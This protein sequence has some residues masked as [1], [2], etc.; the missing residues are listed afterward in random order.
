M[1]RIRRQ[2][3]GRLRLVIGLVVSLAATFTAT[4]AGAA[5]A[6]VALGAASSFAVLAGGGV[7]STAAIP[8]TELN[9]D[10][11][12]CP[13]ATI[14]GFPPGVVNGTIA[15]G[16]DCAAA[17]ADLATAYSTAAGRTPTTLWP[18]ITDLG[19]R[20][21]TTG[22]HNS[23]SSFGIA[24]TLTLDGEG[25]PDAVFVFQAA[26]TLITAVNS[27]V[28]L[29]NGTQACN[30]F[31]QVGSSATLGVG[32]TFAGS[33]LAASAITAN[34]G[35]VVDGRLLAIGAAITLD[36][37]TVTSPVCPTPPS[38]SLS[39]AQTPTEGTVLVEG[40][41][42]EMPVTTVTDTRTDASSWTV[43]AT[44]SDL[45]SAEGAVIPGA[46]ITLAQSGSFTS[47]TGTAGTDGLVS[48]AAV[49]L[50]SVYTYTPTAELAPQGSI[51]AGSYTGSVTQTVV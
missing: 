16:P 35:V 50:G 20:T 30:V 18:P 4:V 27:H 17:Q 25:D 51:P 26:S 5:T 19:G 42:V 3:P 44:V 21:L 37:N 7:T 2:A 36:S 13:T 38:G 12:A 48:A 8:F 14:T 45:V 29:V 49:S 15:D 41:A 31:W 43:T 32:S 22:V 11:G 24:G 28:S 46:D 23:P 6:P 47:G 39:L 34:T 40:V 33:L 9:G 1:S 10:L